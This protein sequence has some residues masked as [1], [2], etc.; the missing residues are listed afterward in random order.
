M[1]SSTLPCSSICGVTSRA[2]PE[3]KGV[4]STFGVTMGAE[5]PEVVVVVEAL[6]TKYSSVP[7]LITAFW[8]LVAV[9]RGLERV[10]TSPWVLSRLTATLKLPSEMVKPAPPPRALKIWLGVEAMGL[11]SREPP[12]V[13]P[14]LPSQLAERP[15]Q[16]TPCS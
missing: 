16:S 12:P 5:L 1:C 10:F 9:T 7:T 3:K 6:V 2:M 8:L 4:S 15:L 14:L 13:M 11:S